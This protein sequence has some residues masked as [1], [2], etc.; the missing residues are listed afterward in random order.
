MILCLSSH[1]KRLQDDA[2]ADGVQDIQFVDGLRNGFIASVLMN[3][4]FEAKDID[5]KLMFLN[6][7]NKTIQ[8]V[9]HDFALSTE[10]KAYIKNPTSGANSHSSSSTTSSIV[11][12]TITRSEFMKLSQEKQRELMSK[13]IQVING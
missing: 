4:K 3:N 12:Q 5:G 9:C 13:K 11:G 1:L 6:E 2:I 7:Q 8:D 10:G